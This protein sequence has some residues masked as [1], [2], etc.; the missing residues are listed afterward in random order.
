MAGKISLLHFPV[1][2]LEIEEINCL[3]SRLKLTILLE[4]VEATALIDSKLTANVNAFIKVNIGNNRAGLEPNAIENITALTKTIS[5]SN[6]ISFKGFLGHAGHS[7][8]C[9]SKAAIERVHKESIDKILK[10]KD[11]FIKQYPNLYISVGDTPTCSVIDDFSMVDEIRPGVFTFCDL[12]QLQIG[13]CNQDNMAIAMTCPVVAVHK[14][15]KEIIVYGGSVHFAS[16]TLIEENGEKIFGKVVEN[17]TSGWGKII[18]GVYLK[19]ISQE[20][21]I[22]K[23]TDEFIKSISIGDIVKIIPVHACTTANLFDNYIT[24]EGEKISRFRF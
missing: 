21:G 8:S 9:R 16:D 11:Q 12:M 18:Q 22:L 4:S 2:V 20:H 3:A 13:A 6:N 7:Y 17:T 19:K 23:A 10:L 5:I 14:E 24:L 1:N 15:K